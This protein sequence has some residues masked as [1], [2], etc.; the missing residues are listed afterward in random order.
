VLA[1]H[2]AN[3]RI[4]KQRTPIRH[5]SPI[6]IEI[7]YLYCCTDRKWKYVQYK[8]TA[9]KKFKIMPSATVQD[10]YPTT[11]AILDSP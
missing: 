4:G 2:K 8:M 3:E 9:N 5:V 6:V 1:Q 7:A 11:G 10:Q